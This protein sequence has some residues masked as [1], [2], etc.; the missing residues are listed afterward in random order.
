MSFKVMISQMLR[1][2]RSENVTLKHQAVSYLEEWN[3]YM[4]DKYDNCSLS[5]NPPAT[6]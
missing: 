4:R 1:R 6:A 2:Q 5:P 3:K